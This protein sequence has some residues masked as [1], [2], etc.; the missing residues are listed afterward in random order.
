MPN[1]D[2]IAMVAIAEIVDEAAGAV[3]QRRRPFYN[4]IDAFQL[5]DKQF[6]RMFRLTKELVREVIELVSPYMQEGTRESAINI[7]TKVILLYSK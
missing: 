1:F 5:Q 7:E 6:V 4:R 3:A 2:E